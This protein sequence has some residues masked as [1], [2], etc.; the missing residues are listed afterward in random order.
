MDVITP[1][2]D[3]TILP[4][5]TRDS[6]L[7]LASSH[8]T[9]SPLPGVSPSLHIY[10]HERTLTMTDIVSFSE[11]GKLLEAF[12]VGTAVIVAPVGKIG[13]DGK[14]IELPKHVK[15]L[16]PI[17]GGLSERIIAIQEGRFEWKGWSVPCQ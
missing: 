9:Q 1:P 5:V 6:V 8:S 3:G 7:T 13:Y 12:C 10:T 16:G 14:D 11:S 4:G 15:G 17:G 2:L